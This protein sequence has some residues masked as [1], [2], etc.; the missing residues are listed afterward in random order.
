MHLLGQPM[1]TTDSSRFWS[2]SLAVYADPAVQK[3]CLELQDRFGIDVNLLLFCAFIGAVHGALL[4]EE[5]ARQAMNVVAWWQEN[6]VTP[7]RAMRR[8]LRELEP[9]VAA[10]GPLVQGVRVNIEAIEL[11]A[12]RIEQMMLETWCLAR[13]DAWRRTEVDAAV[14]AN[15]RTLLAVSGGCA[16][17]IALPQ[18]VIAAAHTA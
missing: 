9:P 3:E 7:L 17:Q 11:E 18:H 6:V 1:T 13:L 12:E 4:S 14:T 8:A 2:F 15:V 10:I 16:Q 5:D